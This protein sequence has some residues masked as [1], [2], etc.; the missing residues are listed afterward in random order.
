MSP[1]LRALAPP[2]AM[3][4]VAL[5]SIAVHAEEYLSPEGHTADLV[6]IQGLLALPYVRAYLDEMR[7]RSLVPE[8][9]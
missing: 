2:D 9:R 5:A 4:T 1:P 6:A 8:R 7:K 3:T